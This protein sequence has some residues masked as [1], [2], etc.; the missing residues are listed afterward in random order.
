MRVKPLHL[1]AALIA[2][3]CASAFSATIWKTNVP[4]LGVQTTGEGGFIFYAPPGTDSACYENGTWFQVKANQ[5][6][7]TAAGASSNLALVLTA[8][9]AGKTIT[10]AYDPPN[11]CFVAAILINP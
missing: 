1:V 11:N 6:G 8:L 2:F 9:A 4:V 7:M 10:I 5:N 3:P